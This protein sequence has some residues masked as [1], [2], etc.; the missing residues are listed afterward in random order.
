MQPPGQRSA[1]DVPSQPGGWGFTGIGK[2]AQGGEIVARGVGGIAEFSNAPGNQQAA[3]GR[4]STQQLGIGPTSRLASMS[5]PDGA[6]VLASGSNDPNALPRGSL[7]NIGDGFGSFSQGQDGDSRLALDRFERANAERAGMVKANRGGIGDTG[8]FTVVADSTRGS[9]EDRDMEARRRLKYGT[10]V[11]MERNRL[12]GQQLRQSGI[13]SYLDRQLRARELANVEADSALERQVKRQTVDSGIP[14]LERQAARLDLQ[15]KVNAG[16][17]LT[18]LQDPNLPQ[19]ERTAIERQYL[20]ARD[21]GAYAKAQAAAGPNTKLTEQQSKDLV[22]YSRGNEANAQL[23]QQGDALTARSSGE[24]GA[25][26]GVVDTMIRGAPWVGDSSVANTLVSTERQQ[27]EQ[28]GRELL[29]SI[30]RKDTGAAITDQEMAIYGRMYLPQPG[31][32]EEVLN[33]KAEARTRALESIRNGMGSAQQLAAP[34]ADGRRQSD[35]SAPAAATAP[36]RVAS[37]ADVEAL[38]SGSLFTGPDGV[39]RRKP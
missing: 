31:D 23:A 21:P 27:A 16:A 18:K 4:F 14:A 19:A 25:V 34:V 13:N 7:A 28:S 17:L 9:L 2:G 5:A 35:E 22:Y 30:L 20:L 10:D 33:Q 24:R 3:Q 29:A 38:P 1:I 36:V 8:N 15:N 11:A 37:R 6:R 32:S 12:E 39:V 26:R